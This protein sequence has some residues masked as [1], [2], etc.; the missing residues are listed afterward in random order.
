MADKPETTSPPEEMIQEDNVSGADNSG[1]TGTTSHA[2]TTAVATCGREGG[3]VV[4]ATEPQDSLPGTSTAT[5]GSN[6]GSKSPKKSGSGEKKK[7]HSGNNTSSK[8]GT[9]ERSDGSGR[10]KSPAANKSPSS[11]SSKKRNSSL[12]SHLENSSKKRRPGQKVSD[13]LSC[14]IYTNQFL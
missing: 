14:G 8:K 4:T 2:A 13:S 10:K 5:G 1:I 3:D 6:S 7:K 11:S 9:P 12:S